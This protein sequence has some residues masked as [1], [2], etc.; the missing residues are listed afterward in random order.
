MNL[1]LITKLAMAGVVLTGV[2][3]TAV[4]G[5]IAGVNQDAKAQEENVN[6][7]HFNQEIEGKNLSFADTFSKEKLTAKELS[8]EIKKKLDE[9]GIDSSKYKFRFTVK[10]DNGG[11]INGSGKVGE[12]PENQSAEFNPTKNEL[13]FSIYL[14]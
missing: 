5:N 3:G 10:L 13:E 14:G 4:V 7:H 9:N 8:D 2:T 11:T 1:S 12:V 6:Q